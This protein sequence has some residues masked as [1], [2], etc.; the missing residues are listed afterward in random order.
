L[1]DLKTAIAILFVL[2]TIGCTSGPSHL[3]ILP[4]KVIDTVI[5]KKFNGK[6]YTDKLSNYKIA[7][8]E[9]NPES[10]K[11][12]EAF[13]EKNADT[14]KG[15]YATYTISFFEATDDTDTIMLRDH[16]S[17]FY[18]LEN[19]LYEYTWFKGK[20]MGRT[21]YKNGES[22]EPKSKVTIKNIPL[23]PN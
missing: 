10:L 7:N 8:Y 16:P 21:K 6:I 20:F 9:D 4:L 2:C 13:V 1:K 11:L 23:T 5:S 19:L 18:N 14:E 22:I 12:L 15:K 17:R 3:V